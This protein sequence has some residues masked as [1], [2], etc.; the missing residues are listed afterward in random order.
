M[1][2]TNLKTDCDASNK[3][4]IDNYCYSPSYEKHVDFKAEIPLSDDEAE[5]VKTLNNTVRS[6]KTAILNLNKPK[7]DV[8]TSEL[9]ISSTQTLYA[10]CKTYKIVL[11]VILVIFIICLISLYSLYN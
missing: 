5:Q 7:D 8:S 2:Y 4:G 3:I 1:S 10:I 11:I 9:M 6:F